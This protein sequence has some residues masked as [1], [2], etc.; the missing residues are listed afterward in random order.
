MTT[1][2]GKRPTLATLT[3]CMTNNLPTKRVASTRTRKIAI[4]GDTG[5]KETTFTVAPGEVRDA[6][7][8]AAKD[9]SY[10]ATEEL[11][12]R[13]DGAKVRDN[14]QLSAGCYESIARATQAR[15]K[16]QRTIARLD[17]ELK[18]AARPSVA[19][20]QGRLCNMAAL[21]S[22]AEL[23]KQVEVLAQVAPVLLFAYF[24]TV[25]RNE[26][27]KLLLAKKRFAAQI[28]TLVETAKPPPRPPAGGGP[29][30]LRRAGRV[31]VPSFSLGIRKRQHQQQDGNDEAKYRRLTKRGHELPQTTVIAMGN[32]AATRARRACSGRL[33]SRAWTFSAAFRK[34]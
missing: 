20:M 5:N 25:Y 12:E 1:R 11:L 31:Q 8:A 29:A 27:H 7:A 22:E 28:E 13:D 34:R 17:H 30:P 33:A 14:R 6:T 23:K 9:P 24:N 16:E 18:R 4:V 19:D 3:G 21:A 32:W 2:T 15:I 26:Q 10:E